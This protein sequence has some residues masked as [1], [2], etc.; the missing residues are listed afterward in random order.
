MSDCTLDL[1]GLTKCGK[2]IGVYGN[3]DGSNKLGNNWVLIPF[4]SV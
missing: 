4:R 3:V 2:G 1:V